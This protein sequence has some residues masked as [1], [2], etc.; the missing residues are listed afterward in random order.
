M[1]KGICLAFGLISAVAFWAI[2]ITINSTPTPSSFNGWVVA[3]QEGRNPVSRIN[4]SISPETPSGAGN[5]PRLRYSIAA[6]GPVPFRGALLLGEN[7]QLDDL[8]LATPPVP[9]SGPEPTQLKESTEAS[10]PLR[11]LDVSTG[12]SFVYPN[13]QI[14]RLALPAVD[15]APTAGNGNETAFFG[16]ATVITGIAGEAVEKYSHGPLGLWAGPQSTQAWPYIGT[17]PGVNPHS[18]GEF[19]FGQSAWSRPSASKFNVDVGSLAEKATVDFA[20]PA[21]SSSTALSWSQPQ[22]YA[23]IARVT[24]E[25]SLGT[26]RTYLVLATISFAIGGSFLAALLLRPTDAVSLNSEREKEA[27]KS[28]AV[29]AKQARTSLGFL[30]VLILLARFTGRNRK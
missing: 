2:S 7:A 29:S 19:R 4:L 16:A 15:C 9:I 11:M 18:L 27:W 6:C 23:A 13:V 21:P 30:I 1:S 5:K 20:R 26:W 17:F 14:V 8:Q 12:H 25:N 3:L 22:P 10:Q 24:D 28:P